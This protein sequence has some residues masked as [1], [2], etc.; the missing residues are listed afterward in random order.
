MNQ[1]EFFMLLEKELHQ[2]QI[3]E[4]HT[5]M[6]YYREI[7]ADYLEDGFSEKEALQKIGTINEIIE[8]IKLEAS[9]QTETNTKK[10]PMTIFLL[11]LGAP[12]WGA[13]LLSI[14]LL[15]C[16]GIIIL[17]C[18][19]L[20]FGSLSFAGLITGVVSLAGASLNTGFY[21]IITQLGVGIFASGFGIFLLIATIY[22]IKL[23]ADLSKKLG[24]S[25]TKIFSQKGRI[26]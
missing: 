14:I 7:I 3:E 22:S 12:L 9:S 16:S 23:V 13:I 19:P 6:T 10:G 26:F 11:I 4:A 1:S 20:V 2:Q 18:V 5:Y 17:W 24:S 15:L 21:Y 8:T 25:L